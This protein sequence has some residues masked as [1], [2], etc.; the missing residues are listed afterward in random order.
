MTFETKDSGKREEFTSGMVR[1]TQEGKA[2]FALTYDGP[3]LERWAALLTRGAVKYAK[4][5]WMK[6]SGQAELERFK[7]SAARHFAQWM[8]GDME[9]DHAAAIAFNVNGA[10]YVK[11]RIEGKDSVQAE[12]IAFYNKNEAAE[13]PDNGSVPQ[14]DGDDGGSPFADEAECKAWDIEEGCFCKSCSFKRD[15]LQGLISSTPG[16]VLNRSLR[17]VDNA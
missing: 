9:E 3:L 17:P 10:E 4:R 16:Q 6:A 13:P 1:D 5:N 12:I 2:N 8:R 14:G 7:E 15:Y 11:D